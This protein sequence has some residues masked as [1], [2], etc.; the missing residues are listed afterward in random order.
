MEE[1]VR[2]GTGHIEPL[3]VLR[4][5]LMHRLMLLELY[6]GADDRVEELY[7]AVDQLVGDVPSPYLQVQQGHAAQIL[8]HESRV[9]DVLQ[10]YARDPE[11][12]LRSLTGDHLLR[13]LGDTVAR[14]GARSLAEPV[15][16][17]L[18]P[19]AGLLNV[20]AG[21]SVGLPVDD[22]LGRLASLVGDHPAAVRHARDAVGLARSIPSPPMLVHCLDHLAD[23]ASQVGDDDAATVRAEAGTLAAAVGVERTGRDQT[24]AIRHDAARAA[25]IR[26]DGPLWVLTSPLG[27]A[28]LPDSTGLGQLARLLTTPGVEVAANEL[29]RRAGTPAAADLGPVLDAQ[30]KR[31]YRRRLLELRAEVDAAEAGNDTVRGEQAHVEI[32]ALLRELKRAVGLGG[33]DRPTGSDAE[34]AR[35]NVVRS[36]RRAIAGIAQQAPLLGAHLDESVRTGRYCV[37][38]P[39]PAAALSWSVEV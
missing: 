14:A 2:V 30:A 26:R 16:H 34:R 23:A 9:H 18:L 4:A 6:G 31:A 38:R 8:G 17:A 20:G 12:V 5:E 3:M 10:R 24:P 11:R 36:L 37:Y 7:H 33:R 19:D 13:V 1:A 25:A 22:V 29:A 21:V 27:G 15:Y 35:V 28:R 32:D 39:A